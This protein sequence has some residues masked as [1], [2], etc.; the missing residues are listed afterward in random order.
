MAFNEYANPT[1]DTERLKVYAD[2]GT[3]STEKWELQGRGVASNDFAT[4]ADVTQELDVLGFTDVTVAKA[5]PTLEMELKLRKN[6]L[7]G[8]KILNAW[9]DRTCAI[10]N[11]SVILKY[12]FLDADAQTPATNCVAYKETGCT[13]AIANVTGE[14]GNKLTVTC[15]LYLSNATVKGYM[16][17]TDGETITF[18]AGTPS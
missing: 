3:D 16:A 10:D 11:L 12:E 15:T 17:K 18:T 9:L 1:I 5:K 7:L 2:V 13:I 4:N 6:S 14:A 8:E